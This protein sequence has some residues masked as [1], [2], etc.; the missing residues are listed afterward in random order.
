MNATITVGSSVS[1]NPRRVGKLSRASQAMP[2]SAVKTVAIAAIRVVFI[3]TP[4]S[5]H[6]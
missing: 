6:Y 5:G 1:S 2:A 4:P 3:T